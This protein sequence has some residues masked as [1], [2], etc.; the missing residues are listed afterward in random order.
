MITINLP[1]G[2]CN[3]LFY[4][5]HQQWVYLNVQQ[6]MDEVSSETCIISW[7]LFLQKSGDKIY[8]FSVLMT[9]WL[10]GKYEK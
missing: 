2:S 9:L 7:L 3:F 1:V 4:H 10:A 6:M 8:C 5:A